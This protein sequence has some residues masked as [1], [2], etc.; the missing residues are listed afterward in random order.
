M[1]LLFCGSP[2]LAAV[3]QICSTPSVKDNLH[4]ILKLISAATS[5]GAK[6]IFFPEASDF[7][8]ENKQQALELVQPLNGEFVSEIKRAAIANKIIVSIGIH[9]QSSEQ[10]RLFN[11]HLLINETG[12]MSLY[13]KIHLFDLNL[14]GNVLIES[15]STIPGEG[16]VPPISTSI[17]RIG[18]ALCYDLRF[19]E[20]SRLLQLQGMDILTY[21]S[22]FTV[23]TGKAH[24][25]ILLRARAIETQ[26]YVIAA[27]QFGQ[28]T[29]TR[30]TYGHALIVDPWGEVLAECTE[31]GL[32]YAEIDLEKIKKIKEQMPVMEHRRTDIYS[33]KANYEAGVSNNERAKKILKAAMNSP[34]VQPFAKLEAA[35]NSLS[36]TPARKPLQVKPVVEV[37][38]KISKEDS[39][40]SL[41][42]FKPK[43]TR[44]DSLN[45]IPEHDDKENGNTFTKMNLSIIND[46]REISRKDLD[47]SI[48]EEEKENTNDFKKQFKPRFTRFGKANRLPKSEFHQ[49]VSPVSNPSTPS[50]SAGSLN[51]TPPKHT[52]DETTDMDMSN[53]VTFAKKPPVEDETIGKESFW[54]V[55]TILQDKKNFRVN[56]KYY[57]RSELIGKGGS[58]K[59]FKVF[60]QNGHVYALKRV[61][62]KGQDGSVAAGYKNEIILLNKL[63]NNE[64]IIK[65]INAEHN[66]QDHVLLMVLEYGEIDL[67][68]M[69]Q[70]QPIISPNFMRNYWEQMLQAVNAI[71]EQNIIHSDLKPANFLLVE[72]CL[73][74]IDFGIAKA[75]PNDTTNIQREHQTGTLN[76]MAPEAINYVEIQG[77]KQNYLKQGRASDVWSLGCILYRLVY[78]APPFGNLALMQ[79]IKCITNPEHIIPYPP[80]P[81]NLEND[82]DVIDV[83]KGCLKYYPKD[84]STIPELLNH[85]FLHPIKDTR[86]LNLIR[87]IL[88]LALQ[89]G[90]TKDNI[91]SVAKTIASELRNQE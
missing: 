51:P 55:K 26:S 68:K 18:L 69:L 17:G 6:A 91:E 56:G 11:T 3:A 50:S 58:C 45:T 47:I 38:P 28:N 29:T 70:K 44:S 53:T 13:R 49:P 48:C 78:Q 34:G 7:I 40:S 4:H 90:L 89:E 39:P 10:T 73:K 12:G 32:Q 2:M 87:K 80:L 16:Y 30:S 75:I 1:D 35:Y 76:Y 36:D 82:Q 65:L 81:S 62:L 66:L 15:K 52:I 60:D 25:H 46:S 9:E 20:C 42:T 5:H 54:D 22:A 41:E 72:G 88:N 64:R 71:H 27:A 86:D 23:P 84:R 37:Q 31:V 19:P 77:A 24:W 8:A 74:L 14:L 43:L 85:P 59:V 57:I 61:K 83:L 63:K 79:K 21:P 33:L 67:E